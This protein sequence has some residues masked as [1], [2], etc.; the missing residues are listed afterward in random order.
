M[1]R[2]LLPLA[3]AVTLAGRIGHWAWRT[4]WL[5]PDRRELRRARAWD[6]ARER[7]TI[8]DLRRRGGL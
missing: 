1:T 7:A 6:E 8:V 3:L 2:L 5:W 4:V